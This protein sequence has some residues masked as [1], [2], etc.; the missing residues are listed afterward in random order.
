MKDLSKAYEFSN[1][2]EKLYERWE[3]EIIKNFNIIQEIVRNIRNIRTEKKIPSSKKIPATIIAGEKIEI[4]RDQATTIITLANLDKNETRIFKDLVEKPINQISFV[5]S[6]VE[7]FLLL[8]D[9]IDV[10]AERERINKELSE[11][12]I[13]ITRLENLLNSPFGEKAPAAVVQKEK[14]KLSQFLET[15][16]KLKQQLNN[17]A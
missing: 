6:G 9:L 12:Q 11:T 1:V 5:I 7:L 15:A 16:N 10:D 17:L 4:I 3:D 8:D 13:Q 2:E 14:E